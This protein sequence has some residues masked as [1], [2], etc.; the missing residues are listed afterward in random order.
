MTKLGICSWTLGIHDLNT[1]MAKIR[2]LGLN[3][4]QYCEPMDRY[5]A[6]DVKYSAQQHGLEILI[7]DPFDCRPGENNGK[8]TIG[9]AVRYYQKAI[10]Y[11]AGLGC[12]Q[13]LQ[14]LSTW[15]TNCYSGSE[16][17]QF[18][19]DAVKILNTYAED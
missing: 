15:T 2:A 8:A 5:S 19:V 3:A 14:G 12:G 6:E 11:A 9:N 13:T 10:D 18:L 7:Y 1:L 16:A 4:V 17:W